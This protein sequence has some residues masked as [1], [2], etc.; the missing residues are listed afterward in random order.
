MLC[1]RALWLK[2]G[3]AGTAGAEPRR[4]WRPTRPTSCPGRSGA[5]TRPRRRG[6][7]S[8]AR[9]GGSSAATRCG[10][11]LAGGAPPGRPRGGDGGRERSG[12]RS[13]YHVGVALDTLDGRCVLG[14]STRGTGPRSMRR[15]HDL[16]ARAAGAVAAAGRR[17]L[18]PV[19]LPARRERPATS[20][21]RW[22]CRRRCGSRRPAGPRRCSRWRTRGSVGEHARRCGSTSCWRTRPCSAGSRSPST[23]PISSTGAGT[24]SGCEPRAAARLVPARGSVR[25]V[26]SSRRPVRTGRR[27]RGHLLDHH[28]AGGG[29]ARPGGPLLPGVRGLVHPQ[30]RRAPQILEA[31]YATADPGLRPGAPPGRDPRGAVRPAGAGGAAGRSTAAWRPRWRLAA[32]PAAARA[33]GA[34]LRERLERGADRARGGAPA[35]RR[36]GQVRLVRLSQWPL[37]ATPSA[38]SS[39]RTSST[40]TST[41]RGGAADRRLRPDAR[42]VLGAGGFRP[43]GARGDGL[44]GAGSG[45]RD[46]GF[47]GFATGAAELVPAGDAGRLRRRGRARSSATAAVAGDAARRARGGAGVLRAA[48]SRT[49]PRRRSAGWRAALGGRGR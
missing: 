11:E 48:G 42:A 36:R 31:A 45:V 40:A 43:A 24:R 8:V 35:A 1:D 5:S 21:T 44:R 18:Q 41:R 30:P 39:S 20:T 16:P 26:P 2:Q 33:G 27:Q 46:L 15:R 7:R 29:A 4:W 10:G 23:T 37:S 38:R 19:R 12:A 9:S 49:R 47:R 13:V 3:P 6:G 22:C 34:P 32:A 28:R 25:A 17:H 14:V